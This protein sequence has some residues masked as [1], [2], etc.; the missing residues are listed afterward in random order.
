V[1][2]GAVADNEV[3]VVTKSG[4]VARHVEVLAANGTEAA[5]GSGLAQGEWVQ[6]CNEE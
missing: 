4:P 2:Q 3:T 5:I 1:P 6:L